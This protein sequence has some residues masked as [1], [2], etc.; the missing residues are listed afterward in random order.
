MSS[1]PSKASLTPNDSRQ[2]QPPRTSSDKPDK[3]ARSPY[4]P[5][6][7]P[8]SLNYK[9]SSPAIGSMQ[10]S[11]NVAVASERTLR[12]S[13]AGQSVQQ[14]RSYRQDEPASPAL[15]QDSPSIQDSPIPQKRPE[16]QRKKSSLASM[17]HAT[18]KQRVAMMRSRTREIVRHV[19][20]RLHAPY[21]S[22]YW[23][24][25]KLLYTT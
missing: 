14:R 8:P 20:R 18:Y 17:V 21:S 3:Y 19:E 15:V 5:G 22:A 9:P 24:T 10:G 12:P 11:P 25:D 1:S 13:L 16:L 23:Y 7:N 6:Y 2:R 4:L